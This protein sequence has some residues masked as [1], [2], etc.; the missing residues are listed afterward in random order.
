[1]KRSTQIGLAA[2]GVVLVASFWPRGDDSSDENLVYNSLADCRAA[3]QLSASQC[4]QRFNEASANHLRDAK[5]FTSTSQCETEYG[6]GS[7]QSAVWNGAQVVIPALAGIMLAR[8]FAQGGGAAQPLLPPTNQACP[9]GSQAEGC[10]QA[11]SSS[12]SSSSSSG[13][14]GYR[15]SS[16][17]SSSARAYSTSSGAT[18]IARAGSSPGSATATSVSSRGGFGSTSHSYSSSSSS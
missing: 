8:S 1:M 7:C 16:S 9:P 17:S 6:S 4:E 3:G 18:V 2:V 5:K 15:S 13:G 10:Q 12:S 14:G 11:R